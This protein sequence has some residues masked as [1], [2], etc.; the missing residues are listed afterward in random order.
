MITI[1]FSILGQKNLYQPNLPANQKFQPQKSMNPMQHVAYHNHKV[2]MTNQ[3]R[4]IFY[5]DNLLSFS[6]FPQN[7]FGQPSQEKL[8]VQFEHLHCQFIPLLSQLYMIFERTYGL[9]ITFSIFC[10]L[11]RGIAEIMR[12]YGKIKRKLHVIRC[13][14]LPMV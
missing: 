7:A 1:N 13:F 4:N 10:W 3:K 6:S 8:Y 2:I 11:T 5:A 9:S 14:S 12:A